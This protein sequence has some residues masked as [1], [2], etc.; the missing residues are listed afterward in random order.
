MGNERQQ[1]YKQIKIKIKIATYGKLSVFRFF[2]LEIEWKK[3][4]LEN[5]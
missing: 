3:K 2:M 5:P 1:Q 4:M